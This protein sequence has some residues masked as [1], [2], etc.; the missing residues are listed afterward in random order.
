MKP[1]IATSSPSTHSRSSGSPGSVPTASRRRSSAGCADTS[2]GRRDSSAAT[3]GANALKHVLALLATGCIWGYAWVQMKIVIAIVQVG[4][5]GLFSVLALE[6]GGVGRSSILAYTFPLWVAL[7]AWP[8]LKE[9]PRGFQVLAFP[10][11]L[12]GVA[13]ILYP[14]D[15]ERG[16]V[17]A[18]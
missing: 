10:I 2:S 18:A 11:A 16:L 5:F 14:F 12:V 3:G 17:G 9:R 13:F 1:R 4:G 7:I 8:V 15:V 6:F